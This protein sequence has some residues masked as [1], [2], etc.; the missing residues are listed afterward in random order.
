MTRPT[1]LTAQP[2][3]TLTFGDAVF[4]VSRMTPEIQQMVAYFDAWRQKEIDLQSELLQVR[5]GL[6]HLKGQLVAA[7]QK[8]R[9]DAVKKAE[10]MG[11]VPPAAEPAAQPEV[12]EVTPAAPASRRKRK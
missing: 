11:V 5:G 3:T 12:E 6:E 9:D 1:L 10:A 7:I 2:T 8:E 4:E